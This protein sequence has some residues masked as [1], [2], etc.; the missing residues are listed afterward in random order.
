[1]FGFVKVGAFHNVRKSWYSLVTP[2]LQ[3]PSSP[4]A[5]DPEWKVWPMGL[6]LPESF[7]DVEVSERPVVAVDIGSS[8]GGEEDGTG[9]CDSRGIG[10]HDFL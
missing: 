8:V 6:L 7:D 3:T 2:R 5:C 10:R 4:H 9:V 1:M